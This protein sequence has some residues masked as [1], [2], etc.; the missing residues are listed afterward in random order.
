[1]DG[2]CCA[3]IDGQFVKRRELKQGASEPDNFIL[4]DKDETTGK[5]VGW[6]PVS[7]GPED[8]WYREAWD[9]RPPLWDGETMELV[10]PKIQGNPEGYDTHRLIVHDHKAL[11]FDD[12]PPRTFEGLR[13]WMDGKDIEGIVFHHQDGRMGKIK[14]RDF[15]LKRKEFK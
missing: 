13:S 7:D 8:R 9:Q 6:V 2:T 5:S 10:G 12:Q 15:G 11:V 4:V 1:M 3:V 14:L